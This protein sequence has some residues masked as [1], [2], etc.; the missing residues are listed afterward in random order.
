MEL[1]DIEKDR[2]RAVLLTNAVIIGP[3]Q[4]NDKNYLRWIMALRLKNRQA[5]VGDTFFGF[6]E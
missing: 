4:S 2:H 5:N 6:C 3:L 1:F